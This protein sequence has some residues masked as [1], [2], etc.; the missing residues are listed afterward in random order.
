MGLDGAAVLLTAYPK[1][2]NSLWP[3][4]RAAQPNRHQRP[5]GCLRVPK[6]ALASCPL[7]LECSAFKHQIFFGVEPVD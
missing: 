4:D 5:T 2:R 6:P 7:W 1:R 3:E